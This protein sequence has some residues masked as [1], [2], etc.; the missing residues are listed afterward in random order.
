MILKFDD[1][2]GNVTGPIL[3]LNVLTSDMNTRTN[4]S[5]RKMLRFLD[6]IECMNDGGCGIAVLS[7]HRWLVKNTVENFEHDFLSCYTSGGI[8][9]YIRNQDCL[10]DKKGDLIAPNHMAY[11]YGGRTWDSSGELRVED[12]RFTLKIGDER[13]LVKMINNVN[14][15]NRMFDRKKY[16]P[17]IESQL[18]IDLS[19]VVTSDSR[20]S[21]R[22]SKKFFSVKSLVKDIF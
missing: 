4:R 16:V 15:W 18:N 20:R 8:D 1:R 5:F 3:F 13:N 12:Y 10:V 21:K 22:F 19:D 7:M 2:T 6:G 11:C 17:M 9:R 14:E